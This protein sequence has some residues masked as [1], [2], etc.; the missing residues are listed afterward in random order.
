MRDE[1]LSLFVT[2]YKCHRLQ[3]LVAVPLA[4]VIC[5]FEIFQGS[6]NRSGTNDGRFD[7]SK[8]NQALDGWS[9]RSIYYTTNIERS[10]SVKGVE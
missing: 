9:R 6:E 7:N 10:S 3:G 8:S 2:V 1:R 5:S 4:L